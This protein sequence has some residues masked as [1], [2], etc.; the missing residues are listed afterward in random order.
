M[1]TGYSAANVAQFSFHKRD[2]VPRRVLAPIDRGLTCLVLI[3]HGESKSGKA[4]LVS[5]C[6]V[7]SKAVWVPKSMVVIEQPSERGI[8]V[9]S[10]AKAFAEQ[11]RLSEKFIDPTL[12]NEATRVVLA[13]AVARAARKRNFYRGHRTPNGRGMTQNAF[14]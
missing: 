14:C 6:G 12:F 5:D 9:A 10:M 4:I 3:R 13:Q 7:H 1:R 8:L 11:K 2:A